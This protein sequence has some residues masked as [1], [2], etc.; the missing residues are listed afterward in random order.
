LGIDWS[1]EFAGLRLR[2]PL[3]LS[4]GPLTETGEALKTAA[5]KGMGAVMTRA[6]HF[7]KGNPLQWVQCGPGSLMNKGGTSPLGFEAWVTNEIQVAKEGGIP[8]LATF[9]NPH[10]RVDEVKQMAEGFS[11]AG[12][13][14]LVLIDPGSAE[15][16]RSSLQAVKQVTD[17][18]VALKLGIGDW[19]QG[20]A[21][22]I[23]KL[24][25]TA[26]DAGVDALIAID[27]VASATKIDLTTLQPMPYTLENRG[28]SL[29]GTA[30]HPLAVFCVSKLARAT[31]LPIMGVGGVGTGADAAEM[32]LVGATTIGICSAAVIQGLGVFRSVLKELEGF[33]ER[34][35]FQ[36]VKDCIGKALPT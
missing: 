15:A 2:N 22:Q 12:A 10:H 33:L 36:A 25:R 11:N 18:P 28:W 1:V 8:V 9:E 30:I 19:G 29:S 23:D 13:D 21:Y 16:I 5:K 26:E 34:H 3:I 4:P 24:G 27:A 20:P 7:E 17:L 32:L 35:K 14:M 31:K 6:L